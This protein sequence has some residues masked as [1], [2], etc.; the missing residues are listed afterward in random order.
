[1][2]LNLDELKTEV[3]EFLGAQGFVVFHGYSRLSDADSFVAWDTERR[4]DYREFL[5]TAKDAGIK[6]IVY[7]FREFNRGHID[8]ATERLEDADI[9]PEEQLTIER[10]LRDFRAYEGFTCALELSFEF[11][12]RVYVFSLR[13]DW[14]EEYLDLLEDID[15]TLPDEDEGEDDSIGGF[16]SRN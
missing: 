7:H 10:R 5:Q 9:N 12:A 8:E 15:A 14:Y 11:Q 16:Y 4:P 3:L 1:M 13:S 6:L 2:G